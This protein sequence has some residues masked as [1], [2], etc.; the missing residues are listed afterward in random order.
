MLTKSD[1]D[2]CFTAWKAHA[3][4]GNT[5]NLIKEIDKYYKNLWEE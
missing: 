3:K 1:V 5:Y 2:D 4:K